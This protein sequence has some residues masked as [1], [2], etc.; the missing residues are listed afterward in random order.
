MGYFWKTAPPIDVTLNLQEQVIGF[1]WEGNHH[2]IRR[3]LARWRLDSG[4][5]LWRQWRDYYQVATAT[6]MVVELYQ[7]KLQQTWHLQRIYD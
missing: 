4:W 1:I 5:W 2:P 6:G 3:V 7:D